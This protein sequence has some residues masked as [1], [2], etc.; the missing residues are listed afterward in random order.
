MAN[1]PLIT[2]DRCVRPTFFW[3]LENCQVVQFCRCVT[4]C[5]WSSHVTQIS[6]CPRKDPSPCS[7]ETNDC[8]K[9]GTVHCSL[10]CSVRSDR[11]RRAGRSDQPIDILVRLHHTLVQT[12]FR[13]YMRIQHPSRGDIS[14]PNTTQRMKLP[15]VL[16]WTK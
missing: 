8:A 2:V 12:G 13:L 5:I 9:A 11:K 10:S 14:V 15:E 4:N 6:G 3:G 1:L 16:Q 7:S